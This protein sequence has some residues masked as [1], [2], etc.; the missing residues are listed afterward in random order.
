MAFLISSPLTSPSEYMFETAFFGSR[1]A[2]SL[3]I[4]S[5]ILGLLAGTAAHLLSKKTSFFKGQFRL[6]KQE[7]E[8]CGCSEVGELAAVCDCDKAS[9]ITDTCG[10]GE[11][12]AVSCRETNFIKRYKIDKFIKEFWNLGMKK[13]LLYFIVFIALGRTAE[14]LIPKE[15]IMMLFGSSKAY[16]VPLAA[17]IGLPLYLTDS[18][19]IPL[20]KSF[21]NSGA[22]QGAV[23][24]F[25][26]AGKATGVPVIAGM[27]TFLKKRA[28]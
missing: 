8:S 13:I 4:S 20:L 26:I 25:L 2:L 9:K 22:G 24:A 15:L 17:T 18:S 23:L 6:A 27:A 28:S 12:Y 14:L 3:L 16:S 10:C 21:I 1:F 7:N 11:E 19:A 5:I